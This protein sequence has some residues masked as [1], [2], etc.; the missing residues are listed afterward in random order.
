MPYLGTPSLGRG[1]RIWADVNA[2]NKVAA[3]LDMPPNLTG[4]G[5]GAVLK[6]QTF[7]LLNV[8]SSEKAETSEK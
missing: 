6:I 2:A 4:S 3:W 7:G 8:V 5:I 1:G